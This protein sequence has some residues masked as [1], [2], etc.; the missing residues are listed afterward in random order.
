MEG[1]R[2]SPLPEPALA[3]LRIAAFP[4]E[5]L[6]PLAAPEALARLAPVLDLEERLDAEV[7]RLTDALYGVAGE[8]PGDDPGAAGSP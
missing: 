8:P 6:E 2:L 4:I 3:L 7:E 5:S 1:D